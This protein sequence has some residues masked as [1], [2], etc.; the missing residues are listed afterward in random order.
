MKQARATHAE[1]EK[2]IAWF[3]AREDAGEPCPEWRR[4]VFGYDVLLSNAADPAK[5]Y[6][7]FKP[8]TSPA[9]IAALKSERDDLA[10]WKAEALLVESR[11]DC[12]RVGK[13]LGIQLGHDIRP[14]I[15]PKIRALLEARHQVETKLND[16]LAELHRYQCIERGETPP[17]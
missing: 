15:E 11:W 8:G 10:R 16:A 4:V 14:N 5:D 7:D 17:P 1:W 6:L 2:L 3:D 12:Q 9:E 13:L